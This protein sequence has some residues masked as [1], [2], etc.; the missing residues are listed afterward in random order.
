[1]LTGHARAVTRSVRTWLTRRILAHRVLARHPTLVCDPST[2]WDYGYDDIDQIVLGTG[3]VVRAFTEI[4]V[5]K[6]VPY[7]RIEGKLMLGDGVVVSTGSN[8]RAA[9]GCIKI[10]AGSVIGQNV[11]VVA[12]DHAV[13]PDAPRFH[14]AWDET[15]SGVTIGRNVW[16]GAASVL[17]AGTEIGDDAVIGAG[18]V[19]R[20][21]VPGGEIWAGAPARRIRVIGS[22]PKRES[23]MMNG[24]PCVSD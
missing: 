17:L 3:V 24:S 4:I 9:G 23:S 13:Q 6:R 22:E 10:G 14:G 11:V 2:I 1:M 16:V 18:S 12:A 8:L 15:R 21:T 19:V 20:G 5:Y 7:S